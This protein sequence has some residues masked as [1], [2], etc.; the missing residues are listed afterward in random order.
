MDL[1]V[2][3]KNVR[4]LEATIPGEFAVIVSLNTPDGGKAGLT[5]E[6]PRYAAAKLVVENRARLASEEEGKAYFEQLRGASAMAEPAA[7]TDGKT[8]KPKGGKD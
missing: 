4:D 7:T 2:Y 6:V 1:R 5:S 8:A 3:Y